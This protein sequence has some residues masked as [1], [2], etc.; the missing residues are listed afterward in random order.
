MAGKQAIKKANKAVNKSKQTSNKKDNDKPAKK[1]NKP[2]SKKAKSKDPLVRVPSC[3][4][5]WILLTMLAI[6]QDSRLCTRSWSW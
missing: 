1:V 5:N 6:G 4:G 3:H 2:G